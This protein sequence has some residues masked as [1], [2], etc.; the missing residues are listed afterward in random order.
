MTPRPRATF[1]GIPIVPDKA[2]MAPV[3]LTGRILPDRSL[4]TA[5]IAVIR[6]PAESS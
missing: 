6:R 5:E 4:A 1:Q 3:T 2:P